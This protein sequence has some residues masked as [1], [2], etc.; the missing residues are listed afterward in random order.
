M[1]PISYHIGLAS[2]IETTDPMQIAS[3]EMGIMSDEDVDDMSVVEVLQAGAFQYNNPEDPESPIEQGVH[4]KRM[5]VADPREGKCPTCNLG[6]SRDDSANSCPG[7]FG[8]IQLFEPIPKLMYLG[9]IK[10]QAVKADPLLN[11][12]N[13]VC[14]HCSKVMLPE[15]Y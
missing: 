14:F 12:L 11:A 2:S 10:N 13:K 15:E 4:D 6:F 9:T 3:L 7:H 8:H 1:P 5:G